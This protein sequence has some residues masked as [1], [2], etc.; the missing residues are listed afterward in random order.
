MILIEKVKRHRGS[1]GEGGA[2]GGR[3]VIVEGEGV[4]LNVESSWGGGGGGG[5]MEGGRI[6]PPSPLVYC[7]SVREGG[8]GKMGQYVRDV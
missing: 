3:G 4:S 1:R 5:G 7:T 8:G 6:A 2:G